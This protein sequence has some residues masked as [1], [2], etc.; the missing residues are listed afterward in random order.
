MSVLGIQPEADP[1]NP[2]I[3]LVVCIHEYEKTVP[4]PAAQFI[5]VQGV[6]DP[7]PQP[8]DLPDHTVLL[9]ACRMEAGAGEW[10]DIQQLGHPVSVY[11]AIPQPDHTWK[12]ILGVRGAMMELFDPNAGVVAAFI[13]APGTYEDGDTITWGAPILEYNA[14][15]ILQVQAVQANLD[16]EIEDREAA[17]TSLD[18]AKLDKSGGT[19]SGDIVLEGKLTLDADDVADVAFDDWVEFT[20]WVQPCQANSASWQNLGYTWKSADGL[21]ALYVPMHAIVGAELVSVDVGVTSAAVGTLSVYFGFTTADYTASI[22]S[23]RIEFGDIMIDVPAGETHVTNVPLLD[24]EE[25]HDPRP[26]ALRSH[27]TSSFGFAQ[28]GLFAAATTGLCGIPGTGQPFSGSSYKHSFLSLK[29]CP[30]RYPA[31]RQCTMEP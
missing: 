1:V 27:Y 25:P 16:Q 10:T 17:G 14:D 19:I 21:A 26:F 31:R 9:A 13:A 4:A 12:I 28:A 15:G 29:G 5:T 8:P 6:P 3:D 23:G 2:R 11:N 18:N 22:I 24:L 7:D 30:T 20:R